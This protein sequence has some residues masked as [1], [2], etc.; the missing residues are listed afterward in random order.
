MPDRTRFEWDRRS[1]LSLPVWIVQKDRDVW[2]W[3]HN[4]PPIEHADGVVGFESITLFP[5]V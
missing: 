3:D 4:V 1:A 2:G 5:T